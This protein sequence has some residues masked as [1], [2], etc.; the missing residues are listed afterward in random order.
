MQ[1]YIQM[2]VIPE[3][4]K[5]LKQLQRKPRKKNISG[6]NGIQTYNLRETVA[7]LYQLSDEASLKAGC[8]SFGIF[9]G[10]SCNCFS[11]FITTMITF[12]SILYPLCIYMI[13][14]IYNIYTLFQC[15]YLST[16]IEVIKMRSH[17]ANLTNSSCQMLDEF[18]INHWH[19]TPRA[20]NTA[21]HASS[22]ECKCS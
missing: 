6:F 21:S 9:S 17:V 16:C 1:S 18:P 11:C 12:T 8:W 5:Q 15:I 13:Y 7:M 3:V 19:N 4:L 22:S 14:I 2:K 10:L 20:G